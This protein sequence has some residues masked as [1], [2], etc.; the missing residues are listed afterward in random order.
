MKL[1]GAICQI[2]NPRFQLRKLSLYCQIFFLICLIAKV[3]F[4]GNL[5]HR[6]RQCRHFLFKFRYYF[7]VFIHNNFRF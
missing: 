1:S 4:M 7:L 3:K 5:G 6:F 2:L